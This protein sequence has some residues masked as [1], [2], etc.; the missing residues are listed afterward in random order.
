MGYLKQATI[1][2]GWMGALRVVSR[3]L[4]FVKVVILA[5]I[6]TPTDF[7]VFGIVALTL[8]FFE[9]ITEPGVNLK[10]VQQKEKI[11]SFVS[12]AW[13]ISLVRGS[14][15]AI[16]IF[17]SAPLVAGFFNQP[18]ALPLL[19]IAAL[20]PL[21][22]GWLNPAAINFVRE[23]H[24]RQEFTLR[25]IPLSLDIITTIIFGLTLRSPVALVYGMIVGAGA[26]LI[27]T[28]TMTS[29]K[30]DLSFIKAK[31]KELF[32]Y[33][34]WVNIGWIISYLAEEFDDI[35]VGRILGPTSLGIYQQAYKLSVLPSGEIAETL[36]KVTFP[37]YS[38]IAT[39]T[40]R[41]WRAVKKTT[42]VT[43]VIALPATL[44]FIFFPALIIQIILG[45]Q[46]LS[47]TAPLQILAIFGFFRAVNQPASAALYASNRPDLAALLRAANFAVMA[48]LLFYL[49]PR[50]QLPGTAT[51]VVIST[52]VVTP[53]LWLSVRKILTPSPL[54]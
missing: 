29:L 24:F 35:L 12:T 13:V 39:D 22:R 3:G 7:G 19:K 43:T 16:A 8:A 9:T 17:L 52:L 48:G 18:E 4:G 47:A 38:K 51:A 54:K 45:D 11:D 30:P 44:V 32:N 1:A 33:G 28:F 25:A 46:W 5:R 20:I 27:L 21:L 14:L 2:T 6:L 40:E 37:V 23:L 26:E 42:V 36:S 53:W 49:V 41:L 34:K 50:Y 15:I 31:A 10:L